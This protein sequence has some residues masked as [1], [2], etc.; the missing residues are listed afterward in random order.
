MAYLIQPADK[1]PARA[2]RRIAQEQS[3]RVLKILA[4]EA[5]PAPETIHDIRK[6]LK[7]LRALY[8]LM[9]SALPDQRARDRCLRDAARHLAALREAD[10]RDATLLRLLPEAAGDLRACR[11]RPLDPTRAER[12]R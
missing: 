8:R 5:R 12:A 2:F 9:A 10:V 3:A 1:T 7:K 11:H 4:A 6:R